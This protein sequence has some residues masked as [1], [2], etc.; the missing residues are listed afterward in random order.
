MPLPRVVAPQD[1]AA[2]GVAE[3]DREFIQTLNEVRRAAWQ[4]AAA[5]AA[6]LLPEALHDVLGASSPA[7]APP[8]AASHPA[9]CWAGCS[10]RCRCR[11]SPSLY[12]GAA[13]SAAV[14][15][16]SRRRRRCLLHAAASL[17][18]RLHAPSSPRGPPRRR[19]PPHPTPNPQPPPHTPCLQDLSRINSYFMEREEE[20]VIRLR[21]LQDARADAGAAPDQLDR[22]RSEVC[23]GGKGGG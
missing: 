14:W 12:L 15:A 16:L 21:A 2:H 1:A 5:R 13:P 19:P 3:E 7:A 4:P 10:A 23:V 18:W 20:A 11:D 8:R 17:Y 6:P 9:F 22:L